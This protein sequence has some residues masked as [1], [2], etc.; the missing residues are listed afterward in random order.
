[1]I[2]AG[3]TR[4]CH[5]SK[6]REPPSAVGGGQRLERLF[7]EK[8]KLILRLLPPPAAEKGQTAEAEQADRGRLRHRHQGESNPARIGLQLLAEPCRETIQRERA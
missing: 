8:T 6:R 7:A 2:L 3:G 5:R 1:M 4:I